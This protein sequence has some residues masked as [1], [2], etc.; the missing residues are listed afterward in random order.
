M[1]HLESKF[2]KILNLD[3]YSSR[4]CKKKKKPCAVLKIFQNLK[5]H[6]FIIKLGN[7][8]NT[9]PGT[10]RTNS[11]TLTIQKKK[12]KKNT[13]DRGSMSRKCKA[14]KYPKKIKT[15]IYLRDGFEDFEVMEIMYE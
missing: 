7:F 14:E 3:R 10:K 5:Y 1:T 4:I 6:K 2:K 11:S 13:Y 8:I 12:Y 15:Y 9:G